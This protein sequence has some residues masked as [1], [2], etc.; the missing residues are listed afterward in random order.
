MG[1]ERDV[2][3]NT[4]VLL[5]LLIM[6]GTSCRAV[7]LSNIKV[8]ERERDIVGER[9]KGVCVCL[10]EREIRRG[11]EEGK[12]VTECDSIYENTRQAQ[13]LHVK[14]VGLVNLPS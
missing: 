7:K 12:K 6:T 1:E 11:R 5:A 3:D 2:S 8:Q 4:T 14:V 13:S 10:C 9:G